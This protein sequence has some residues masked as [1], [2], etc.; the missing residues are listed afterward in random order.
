MKEG[1]WVASKKPAKGEETD[2]PL[3]PS[4]RNAAPPKP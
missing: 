3:Q 2:L 1:T 4:K